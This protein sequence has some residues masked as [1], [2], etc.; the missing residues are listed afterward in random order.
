LLQCRAALFLS[1]LLS[2]LFFLTLTQK[3]NSL[4]LNQFKLKFNN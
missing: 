3:Y 4:H 1:F 2:S